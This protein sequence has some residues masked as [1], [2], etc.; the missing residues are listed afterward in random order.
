MVWT[1]AFKGAFIAVFI[2][3]FD[4][5]YPFEGIPKSPS[6]GGAFIFG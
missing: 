5:G 2:F 4:T 3:A 6:D 1:L